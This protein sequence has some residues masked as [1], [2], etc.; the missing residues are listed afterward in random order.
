[1][2]LVGSTKWTALGQVKSEAIRRTIIRTR[3]TAAEVRTTEYQR[4]PSRSGLLLSFAVP[5]VF[6]S[7]KATARR[8]PASV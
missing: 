6:C 5:A 7:K 4:R 1:M 2:R 8:S 3:T